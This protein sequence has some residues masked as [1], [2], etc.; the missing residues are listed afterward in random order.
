VDEALSIL[1][2]RIDMDLTNKILKIN[3]DYKNIILNSNK[4][5]ESSISSN[6][7]S[8]G[9]TGLSYPSA[10]ILSLLHNH[11]LSLP[12]EQRTGF[13]ISTST[14]WAASEQYLYSNEVRILAGLLKIVEGYLD[15][16]KLFDNMSFTDV[17]SELRKDNIS[18]L[19]RVLELCRSHIN[20]TAKNILLIK[21]SACHDYAFYF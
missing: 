3:T 14:V 18:D 21:V 5:L 17:V 11:S 13:S 4:L 19:G 1:R 8:N 9:T 2:G 10:Q 20:L 7:N 6:V 16:E 15:V 12:A